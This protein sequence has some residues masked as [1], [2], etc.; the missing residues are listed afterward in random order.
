MISSLEKCKAPVVTFIM[1][2]LITR[3]I[4]NML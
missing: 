3:I 2:N 1:V 4:Y